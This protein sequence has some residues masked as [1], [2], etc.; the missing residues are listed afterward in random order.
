M[1]KMYLIIILDLSSMIPSFLPHLPSPVFW[2]LTVYQ[3]GPY[4]IQ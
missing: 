1:K 3:P 4:G 2:D